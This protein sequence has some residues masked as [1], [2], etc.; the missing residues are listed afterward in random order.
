MV[1]KLG[2]KVYKNDGENYNCDLIWYDFATP[3]DLLP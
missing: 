1:D 2:W 3:I